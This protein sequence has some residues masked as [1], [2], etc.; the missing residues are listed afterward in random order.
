MSEK[1]RILLIDDEETI[2]RTVQLYL[3]ATGRYEVQTENDSRNALDTALEFRPHLAVLDIV[4]PEIDGGEVVA[5]LQRQPELDGI[6]IIFLTALV[7]D[8]EVGRKGKNVGGHPFMAK[9]V[10]PASLIQLIDKT[11][12]G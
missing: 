9:P 8:A 12:G 11:V 2:T 1:T 3:E 6:R 10:E 4:M 7:K 5:Q